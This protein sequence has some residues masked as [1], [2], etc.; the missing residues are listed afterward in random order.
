MAKSVKAAV[1]VAHPDDVTLWA[2]GTILMHADWQ[3]TVVSLC[4]ASDPDRAPKFRRALR[5]LGAK[6]EI[7][8]L[9][10]GPRQEPLTQSDIRQSILSLLPETKFS[11]IMTHSPWG[12]Y[13]RHLRH[14]ETSRAV[15][16][17]WENGDLSAD[18]LQMFAYEDGGKSYLPRP[19]KSAHRSVNLP[20]NIWQQK[21]RIVTRLYGFE[22][23]SYEAKIVQ[24]EEAFWCFRSVAEFEK[25]IKGK[26][27]KNES[28]GPV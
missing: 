9:D 8:D 26:G 3:W 22:P 17:L 23:E 21:Y 20:D 2:G 12:E 18:E 27:R 24:R 4:R 28:T 19:I 11:L 16:S 15:A 5:E 10:D 13:T 14:E 25:W 1:I 6:G 7:G